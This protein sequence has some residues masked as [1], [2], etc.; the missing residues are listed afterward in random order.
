MDELEALR[1]SRA[2]L[3]SASLADR[4]RIERALHDGV[5]QDLTAL[6][7]ALQLARDDAALEEVRRELRSALDRARLLAGDVYPSIL[8]AQGLAAALRSA[9]R[10]A[11]VSARIET[12][13][14][15]AAADV[16]AVAFLVCR[17]LFSRL[18]PPGRVTVA[19]RHED[20]ALRVELT[21]AGDSLSQWARDLV[22]ALHGM[23]V[24]SL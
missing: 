10:A 22:D 6:M 19:L 23:L 21:G 1:E 11:G 4:R 2:R 16:E 7:V 3:V 12:D 5:L 24:F 8:D 15:R 14:A 9:A 13:R 20:E 17:D 18:D